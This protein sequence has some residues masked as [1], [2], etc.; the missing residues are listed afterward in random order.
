VN[1]ATNIN[2]FLL[3][4]AGDWIHINEGRL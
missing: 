3:R 1:L 2:F 4:E